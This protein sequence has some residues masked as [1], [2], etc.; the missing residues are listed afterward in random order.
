MGKKSEVKISGLFSTVFCPIIFRITLRQFF[1]FSLSMSEGTSGIGIIFICF[2][3]TDSQSLAVLSF[4]FSWKEKSEGFLLDIIILCKS[5][6]KNCRNKFLA[7]LLT[8]LLKKMW[9]VFYKISNISKNLPELP[10]SS[11]RKF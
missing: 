11:W 8:K 4:V 10:G 3:Y 9:D 2:F 1:C 6:N 7:E 5:Y